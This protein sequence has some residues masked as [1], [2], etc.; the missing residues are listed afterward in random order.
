MTDP[1]IAKLAKNLVGFSTKVKPGE[2]VLIQSRNGNQDLVRCLV[3]EVYQAGGNPFVWMSDET[4]ERTLMLSC[5]EAQLKLRAEADA[6]LMDKMQAYIG[7]TGFY[8]NSENS[9]VPSEK[10]ALFGKHYSEP[11]HGMIRVPKTRWVVLRYP[12]PAMAQMA[13]MSTEGFEDFYFD[14]CNMDYSKM[15]AAMTPLV[16][17]MHKTDRVHI[18]GPGTDLRFSIKGLPAIKCAGEMNIPDG[19]VFTAPVRESVNGVI[20]YN[21]PS[22]HD[23]FSFEHVCLT[24]KDGRIVDAK[25]NDTQRI[26]RIFDQDA[27]ARYV[28][29]F[30]IGVNPY[31]INPMD[32]ILFDEKICG[33][34][35]FTPGTC[36]DECD[37]G[38]KSALHWDLVCIQTPEYG[39]GE[40]YFD[41]VLIRKD[42]L[43][44]PEAL[45]G[46]NPE[47]LL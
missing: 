42:G 34:F 8:N 7:V 25:A 37:N 22:T 35:H 5:S 23:G 17:W 13:K 43:F 20:T 41:D 6:F 10:Q 18:K 12:T 39:G 40:M 28:G 9:D 30:A 26:N 38:N 47:N 16:E 46:L 14:V 15:D 2:N 45:K 21:T 27:G 19:E 32:N 11:V 3:A 44:V 1:R 36:Y 31:I 33:S 29:E 4:V 24:F